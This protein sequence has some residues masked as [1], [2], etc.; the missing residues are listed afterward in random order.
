MV[1]RLTF[2][3]LTIVL[4]VTAGATQADTFRQQVADD[5]HVCNDPQHGPT[6]AYNTTAVHIRDIATRRRVGYLKFDISSLKSAGKIFSDVCLDVCSQ[7]AGFGGNG[8]VVYGVIESQES[9]DVTGFNQLKWNMA[10]GVQNDPL[11]AVDSPVALDAADLVGPLAKFNVPNTAGT[12]VTSDP[13][14]ALDDFFNSDTN[15]T[16]VLLLAPATG[17]SS[18]IWSLRRNTTDCAYLVGETVVGTYSSSRTKALNPAPADKA[19][20]VYRDTSLSWMPGAYA[21]THNVYLGTR[22]DDV[23][24]AD[25]SNPLGVLVSQGQDANTFDPGRLQVGT[26]YYWRVDEVNAP[27]T[28]ST[29]YTGAVWSFTVEPALYRVTNITA[30]ASSSDTG[31]SPQNTVNDSGMNTSD[32]H[33]VDAAAMWVTARAA[34]GPAWIQYAF[35]RCYKLM[36]M[37]VWNYNTEL[38]P[39]L[40]FGLKTVAIEYS[41]DNTT[42][43]A[44]GD[45]DLAQASGKADYAGNTTVNLGG[46]AAQYLRLNIKSGWGAYGQYGLSEVRFYQ[47]PG[48]ARMPTPA[49]GATDVSPDV[50]LGWRPGRESASSKLYL[51][52]DANALPLESQVTAD[53]YTLNLTLGRTYYWRVDEVNDAAAPGLWT[54]DIWSFTTRQYNT[55]DDFESY[56]DVEADRIYQTWTDGYG[57]TTNGSQVGNDAA[58]FA[59]QTILHGGKQS[60]PMKYDNSGTAGISEAE[61]VWDTAQDWTANGADTLRLYF[62]GQPVGFQELAGDHLVMSGVGSDLFGTADQ[63]RFIYKQLGGDGTIIARVDSLVDTHEFALAGLMIRQSTDAGSTYA[64]VFLTGTNGVRFRAR[65]SASTAATSDTTVAT[66]EQKALVEPVWLKLERAG[67]AFNASYSADGKTWT[68]MAWNPQTISMGGTILIGLAVCSHTTTTITT[69]EFSNIAVTGP[70]TG[71]W[72]NVDLGI[73]QSSNTADQLYVTI[74]DAGGKSKTVLAAADAVL[75]GTWQEWSIPL[76]SLTGVST[77]RVKSMVI[78]VGDK[79]SP[80]KGA[81]WLY[82]DDIAVGHFAQ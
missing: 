8:V 80:K 20:D 66:A 30:T 5:G 67:N 79:T 12:R 69:A 53:S 59:E 23:N 13:N 22:F 43:T 16:V 35:D 21:Q 52:T 51:G 10:P 44:L 28:S 70:V 55:V 64:G 41:T 19:T 29:I 56:T 33:A 68:A 46:I 15:G 45:F 47:V 1:R 73:A 42:W 3:L 2:S 36:E 34:T 26:T 54:G 32:Q 31:T 62:R 61:R 17:Q 78:G 76:S 75:Q 58:P 24:S 6:D 81:G 11:P 49:A 37:K 60:M 77:N 40:G 48:Y 7:G 71:S 4:L 14:Q 50:T 57:T 25:L 27:P 65:T 38:E 74:K 39:F 18:L 9:I 72:T 63:G 82:F